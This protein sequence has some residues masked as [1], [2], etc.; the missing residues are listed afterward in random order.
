M[1]NLSS[2][3]MEAWR[4]WNHISEMLKKYV[5]PEILYKINLLNWSWKK[6]HFQKKKNKNE[7]FI[8]HIPSTTKN[9]EGHSSSYKESNRIKSDLQ[10]GM[11]H[12][13]NITYVGRIMYVDVYDFL[14][15][16]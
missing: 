3:T 8:A 14:N 12:T 9:P 4:Q 16:E 7:K 11:E 2:E 1:S 13:G 6:R 10:E 5:R 15:F